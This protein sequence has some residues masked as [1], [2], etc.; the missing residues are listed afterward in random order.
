MVSLS[1]FINLYLCIYILYIY[2]EATGA[3]NGGVAA[4]AD[5][6]ISIYRRGE[7]GKGEGGNTNK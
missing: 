2:L 6:A 4:R 7:G 1:A 3:R 5:Y